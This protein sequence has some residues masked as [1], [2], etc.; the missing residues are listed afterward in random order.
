MNF[1]KCQKV[2]LGDATYLKCSGDVKEPKQTKQPQVQA[3]RKTNAGTLL[4]LIT[5][6]KKFQASG[7]DYSYLNQYFRAEFG[8]SGN[9][10][11]M[12][13]GYMSEILTYDPRQDTAKTYTEIYDALNKAPSSLPWAQIYDVIEGLNIETMA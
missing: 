3:T 12:S 10:D 9:T 13:Y 7:I 1:G 2:S 11:P 5:R 6:L 8:A 4:A